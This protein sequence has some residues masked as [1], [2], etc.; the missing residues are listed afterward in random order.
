MTTK[1]AKRRG[2]PEEGAE[3]TGKA[4]SKETRE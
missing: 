3:F 4:Y 2:L 1:S